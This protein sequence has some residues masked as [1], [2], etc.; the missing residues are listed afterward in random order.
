MVPAAARSKLPIQP[1]RSI[2]DSQGARIVSVF[3]RCFCPHRPPVIWISPTPSG[4]QTEV[5]GCTGPPCLADGIKDLSSFCYEDWDAVGG[6]LHPHSDSPGAGVTGPGLD[7]GAAR[8]QVDLA[9]AGPWLKDRGDEEVGSEQEL[10]LAA[11]RARVL[12]E[13]HE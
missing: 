1:M 4:R 10:V 9:H 2:H 12:G 13:V 11:P 8:R 5:D 6:D 7:P 3:S